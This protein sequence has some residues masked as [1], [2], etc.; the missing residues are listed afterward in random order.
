MNTRCTPRFKR[1][2]SLN[3][4]SY[5]TTA[6]DCFKYLPIVVFAKGFVVVA[7]WSSTV[8]FVLLGRVLSGVVAGSVGIAFSQL[9]PVNPSEQRHV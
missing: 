7:L 6:T 2:S 8:A 1:G 5:C 3:S 4:L 9:S